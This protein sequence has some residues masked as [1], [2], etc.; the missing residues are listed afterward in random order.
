MAQNTSL[1]NYTAGAAIGA[2]LIVKP[3]AADGTVVA[4]AGPADFLMGVN[5]SVAPA[6]GERVDIVKSG[7]ADV[8]F[9][10]A[11]T[12]GQPLTS[13]ATGRAVAAAPAVGANVRIIGFAEESAVAGDIG[14]MLVAPGLMQG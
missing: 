10:G 3:G 2:F 5:D 6:L 13:D 11:V 8:V 9:G 14:P 4:A 1:R 7:I 12:R